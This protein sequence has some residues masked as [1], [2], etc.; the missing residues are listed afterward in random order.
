MQGK[1]W[2]VQ[3]PSTPSFCSRINHWLLSL[4]SFNWIIVDL[5][6]CVSFRWVAKG[7][8]YFLVTKLCLTLCD[9][10]DYYLPG[11][12]VH[13][14]LQARILEWA[15]ISFS[16]GSSCSRDWTWV[17]CIG[18]QILYHWAIREASCMYIYT[19]IY[20]YIHN[21]NILFS[22]FS[23]TPSSAVPSLKDPSPCVDTLSFLIHQASPAQCHC[24]W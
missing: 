2:V 22:T 13:G 7:F 3:S 14:I 6:Y 8:S 16:R 5:Q 12:S 4:F 11:S 19:T 1:A 10:M 18:R 9:R 17:S 15:A 24:V 21:L 23:F 20:I